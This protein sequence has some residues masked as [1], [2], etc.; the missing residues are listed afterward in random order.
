[1]NLRVIDTHTHYA[2]SCFDNV[3]EELMNEMPNKGIVAVVEAGIGFSLNHRILEFCEKNEYMYAALGVHPKYAAELDETKFNQ[4]EKMLD[5]SDKILAIGETGLDFSC[6]KDE[7]TKAL[8]KKWFHRFIE[9]AIHRGMP[10]VIHCRDAYPDLIRIL[11]RYHFPWKPGIIHC[12]SGTLEEA[13]KLIDLGF[14]LGIGGKFMREK[15]LEAVIKEIPLESIVLETD[16][17][18]LSPI[19]GEKI[20]TSM[21]LEVIV[22]ELAR[23]KAVTR[24]ELLW[25]TLENTYSLYPKLR[26]L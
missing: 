26:H 5:K 19:S 21:N 7:D 9:L 24:G 18:Y 6:C 14:Y 3:R 22:E 11:S 8:Q 12:F 1:M 25:V 17:P 23:I 10:M 4:I 2:L 15:S 16:A 13:E 20:N